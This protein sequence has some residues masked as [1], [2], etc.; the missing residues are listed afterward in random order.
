[1]LTGDTVLDDAQS[2]WE[3]AAIISI[4]M[5]TAICSDFGDQFC[6][7]AVC[8]VVSGAEDDFVCKCPR[9]G[10]YYNAAEKKCEYKDSCKTKECTYGRCVESA[11]GK[12]RCGCE[13]VDTLTLSCKI[14]G[15]F[16]DDCREMGGTARLRRGA[17]LGAKCDCGEWGAMDKIKRKC[18]PT[19][20]LRPDLT[21]K[22][23]CENNLLQ[24]GFS[25]L[26]GMELYKLFS[27]SS[28]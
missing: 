26:R 2:R 7:N 24:K 15:W 23:L 9:D 6:R 13:N 19:T 20:C 22:Y 1:S 8:E 4:R 17:F 27:R 25:L 16:I 5:F 10:M 3:E 11:P 12:T 18:V 28:S 14:Q 21:C